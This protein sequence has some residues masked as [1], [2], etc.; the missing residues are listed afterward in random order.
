MKRFSQFINEARS[1]I[2]VQKGALNKLTVSELEK[3]LEVAN[4]FISADTKFICKWMIE[5]A[6]DFDKTLPK[7]EQKNSIADFFN[8]KPDTE[9]T[10]LYAAVNEVYKSGRILEIPTLLTRKQFDDIINKRKSP[11]EIILGLDLDPESAEGKEARN[12]IAKR[13]DTLVHKIV[14]SW[15]GKSS[16]D[17]DELYAEGLY[18]LTYAMHTYGKKSDK[19]KA[20]EE[21]TARAKELAKEKGENPDDIKD[22]M[23]DM[24]KYYSYPF[25]QY[26]AQMIRC[27]ILEAIK[28]KSHTVRIPISQQK[29]Q[30]EAQGYI[31]K[32]NTVSGDQPVKDKDGGDSSRT[33]FDVNGGMVNPTREIDRAEI[34]R[35]WGEIMDDLQKKF[36]EKTIDIFKNHFEFDSDTYQAMSK[37]YVKEYP[38]VEYYRKG[39]NEDEYIQVSKSYVADH[40]DETYYISR[41]KKL[42]GKDMAKRYGFKSPSSITTEVVKV[43]TYI[44]KDQK[45]FKRFQHIND[46]VSEAKHDEDEYSTDVEPGNLD[47]RLNEYNLNNIENND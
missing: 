5:H 46:L 13:Y 7:G 44:K 22:V 45:M 23:I 35:L 31:N 17:K 28:H 38:D 27:W 43:I 18:G 19:Q 3:Y 4:N 20:R 6:D 14:N 47:L 42:S 25:L 10:K 9:H 36:G 16:L 11:D 34:D 33:Y 32:N 21:M 26:A 15:I 40:P 39:D 30:K 12:I 24:E 41:F 29:R 37:E 8:S 1:R 2:S